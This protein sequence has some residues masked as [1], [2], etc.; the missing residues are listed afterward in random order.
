MITHLSQAA[1]RRTCRTLS[2]T[3]CSVSAGSAGRS[4]EPG[5]SQAEAAPAASMCPGRTRG[6]Q[7]STGLFSKNPRNS[8]AGSPAAILE[9]HKRYWHRKGLQE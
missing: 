6:W 7:S 3:L 9:P 2:V 4:I 1:P 5:Y 8:W